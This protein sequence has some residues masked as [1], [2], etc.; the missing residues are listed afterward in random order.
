V[1]RFHWGNCKQ[2]LEDLR[3]ELI[4]AKSAASIAQANVNSQ[5]LAYRELLA[6]NTK[7]LE[8]KELLEKKLCLLETLVSEAEAK[9]KL[10]EASKSA[11]ETPAPEIKIVSIDPLGNKQKKEPAK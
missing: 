8:D 11:K 5:D 10:K 1:K 6:Q 2:E 7:L 3:L 9:L 4:K